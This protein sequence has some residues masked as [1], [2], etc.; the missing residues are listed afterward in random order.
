MGCALLALDL[1]RNWK[2][3]PHPKDNAANGAPAADKRRSSIVEDNV[4]KSPT[5]SVEKSKGKPAPTV[6]K[7]PEAS[8][9]LDSFGF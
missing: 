7:E 2:F 8:S 3:L 5:K 4:P 9:L 6:F 1:V